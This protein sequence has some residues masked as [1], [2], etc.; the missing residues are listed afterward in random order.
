VRSAL[1]IYASVS[2]MKHP[3]ATPPALVPKMIGYGCNIVAPVSA[4]VQKA[5]G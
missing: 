3:K 2:W 5:T 4:R 1:Y